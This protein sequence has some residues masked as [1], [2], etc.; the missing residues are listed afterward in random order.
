MNQSGFA[1]NIV[2]LCALLATFAIS[3][4]VVAL[5]GY[6]LPFL[7]QGKPTVSVDTTGSESASPI[8]TT[9]SKPAATPVPTS[10]CDVSDNSLCTVIADVKSA[11]SA[12][13]YVGFLAYHNLQSITC[14]PEGMFISI[15]EGVAKGVVKQGYGI[16]YNQSE[17]T[18]TSKEGYV[19]SVSS[20]VTTNG[21]FTYR[22]SLVSADKGVVV[23]LN[24][25]KDHVLV[26]PMKRSGSTWRT[27][28][29]L[30]GGTFGDTAFTTMSTS[31]LDL[32]P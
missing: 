14:D 2:I 13:N 15:C 17:G 27:N 18:L 24:T 9:T 22:G 31:L 26:F 25:A 21:P 4:T 29:L 32:V 10:S 11:L 12:A 20:Y 1:W 28:H 23:F 8:P 3:A 5:K 6:S 30:L 16:G 7:S 19:T